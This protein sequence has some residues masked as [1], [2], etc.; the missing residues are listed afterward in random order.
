MVTIDIFREEVRI[1]VRTCKGIKTAKGLTGFQN[2][3]G[4]NCR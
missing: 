3:S 4:L 1:T 2:Q